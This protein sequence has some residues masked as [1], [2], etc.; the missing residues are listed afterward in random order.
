MTIFNLFINFINRIMDFGIFDI[1]I[2]AYLITITLITIIYK[3]IKNI[4]N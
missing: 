4:A 3:I 2:S 1:K